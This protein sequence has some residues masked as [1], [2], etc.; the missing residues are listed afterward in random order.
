MKKLLAALSLRDVLG[1]TGAASFTYGAWLIYR[2]AGFL[3]AGVFLLV[4][5]FLDARATPPQ[6]G[7]MLGA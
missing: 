3:V 2:P 5:A 6:P 4:G 7:R 1:V